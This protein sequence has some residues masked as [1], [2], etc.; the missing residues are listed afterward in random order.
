MILLSGFLI[1]SMY[2]H[3]FGIRNLFIYLGVVDHSYSIE[4]VVSNINMEYKK[5]QLGK[6]RYDFEV[7][8]QELDVSPLYRFLTTQANEIRSSTRHDVKVKTPSNRVRRFQVRIPEDQ[9]DGTDSKTVGVDCSQ[10]SLEDVE[11][12]VIFPYDHR[13]KADVSMPYSPFDCRLFVRTGCYRIIYL[14]LYTLS[15][16]YLELHSCR[17]YRL[18]QR[19]K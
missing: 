8:L 9:K 11:K 1:D 6:W 12:A 14:A 15:F 13:L 18:Q 16:N 4:S 5:Q 17:R 10:T 3:E 7:G 19:R 2:M